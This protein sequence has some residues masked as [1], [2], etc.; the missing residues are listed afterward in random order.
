MGS[1]VGV[2]QGSVLWDPSCGAGLDKPLAG[3]ADQAGPGVIRSPRT[4]R[5]LHSRPSPSVTQV[6]WLHGYLPAPWF[7]APWLP[8]LLSPEEGRGEGDSAG[9]LISF[10]FALLCVRAAGPAW[11]QARSW[12][13]RGSPAPASIPGAGVNAASSALAL[14]GL[15]RAL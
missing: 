13:H 6:G 15:C 4:V 8:G 7:L 5:T 11:W 12:D 2:S 14:P 9:V 10:D 3:R 1:G